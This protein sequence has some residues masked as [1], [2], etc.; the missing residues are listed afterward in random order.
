MKF[1]FRLASF[2][3]FSA[4]YFPAHAGQMLTNRGLNIRRPS[5]DWHLLWYGWLVVFGF[6][7]LGIGFFFYR[8]G[9][10]T[11]LAHRI[12]VDFWG[13]GAY[14]LSIVTCYLW[15]FILQISMYRLEYVFAAIVF[16]CPLILVMI[17][18]LPAEIYRYLERKKSAGK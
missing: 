9:F 17:T 14:V 18:I 3:L 6:G 11:R 13:I 15:A 5:T 10:K 16:G 12:Y 2:C 4:A 1:F 7:L 8:K